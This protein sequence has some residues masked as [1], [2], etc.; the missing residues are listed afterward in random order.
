[1]N[2]NKPVFKYDCTD[3]KFCSSDILKR[4]ISPY[5]TVEIQDQTAQNVQSY[6]DLEYP[7]KVQGWQPES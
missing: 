5:R 6:L 2:G 3:I 1:M 4:K 7:Q